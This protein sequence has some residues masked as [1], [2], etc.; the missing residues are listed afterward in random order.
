MAPR[1]TIVYR[2]VN[3]KE[4]FTEWL[5]NLRDKVAVQRIRVRLRRVAQGLFGDHKPVGRGVFELR[6]TFGPGYRV[7]FAQD[8]GTIVLLLCGGD[9]SSQS[10]DI[11]RAHEYWTQYKEGLQ[12]E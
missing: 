1:E 8:G 7:Y 9:K 12:D 3:G 5:E 6:F 4:P 11:A 2:T 10:E